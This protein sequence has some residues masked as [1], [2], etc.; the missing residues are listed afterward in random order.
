MAPP[1]HRKVKIIQFAIDAVQ[2]E[3]QVQTWNMANN[4]DDGE[5]YYTQC[6]EGEFR[7]EPEP[8]YALELTFFAD[9]RSDGISDFL[10][11]HDGERVA[12]QLDHHPDIPAE[13]VRWS[14]FLTIKAPSAGGE[15][16]T[17]EMT[18]STLQVEGKPEYTRVGV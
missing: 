11:V 18:E 9:W 12:F 17:T 3:C 14:G 10:T 4:T 16:R 6:P 8:D 1:H 7:E 5:R 15:A 2:F 13:H